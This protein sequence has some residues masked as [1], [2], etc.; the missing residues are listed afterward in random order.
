MSIRDLFNKDKS[1][2]ILK[3]NSQEELGLEVESSGNVAAKLKEDKRFLPQVDFSDPSNFAFYG[4][5][6]QYYSDSINRIL[7]SYPYDGSLKERAE[8]RND[9]IY[10]D[11]YVLDNLYPR[12]NGYVTL[13]S[14]YILVDGG[15]NAAPSEYNN[16]I[17]PEKFD[18]SN[19][20]SVADDRESNLE[21]DFEKGVTVEFWMKFGT[22]FL[23]GPTTVFHLTGTNGKITIN[24]EVGGTPGPWTITM[25]SGSTTVTQ[26]GWSDPATIT[27]WNHYAFS[28]ASGSTGMITK[29]Y[30][31]GQLLHTSATL[32]AMGKVIA[33]HNA[34]INALPNGSQACRASYDEFRFWKTKR[35]SED[36]GRYWFTQVGGGTNTDLANTD[37]G[38]YFKFNE[39][40]TGD[41]ST[42]SAILDYSGRFS[43]GTW[44]G[45]NAT[46]S[47]RS[48]GSAMVEASA[49]LKEFKD[50]IIYSIHPD[51]I[52]LKEA[53]I[54]SGSA[55]DF[56]NNSSIYH[57]M[58]NWIV[59]EDRRDAGDAV[60]KLTQVMGSY[61]DTLQLQMKELPKLKDMSYPQIDE[62]E[63]PNIFS[64]RLL[65]GYGFTAP[66]IFANADVISQILNRD[67]ER[68]FDLELNDIKNL[69]YKNIYNNLLHI[70]K[71]KGT[72]K[73]FRN[74]IRCY[75][76]DDSLIRLNLY[77]DNTLIE[78]N[79]D[80]YR[81]DSVRKKY[82]DFNNPDRFAG[83]VYQQTASGNVNSISYI[84]AS[85]NFK[86][87]SF[88][89]EGEILFPIKLEQSHEAYFSTP[90][91]TAS[92]LGF[93]GTNGGFTWLDPDLRV[94]AIRD[95]SE[96]SNIRFRLTSSYAGINLETETYDNT[97]DNEKWNL[98]VR[99]KP[100]G[101]GTDYVTNAFDRGYTLEFY[102]VNTEAGVLKNEF[103]LS[104]SLAS[105]SVGQSFLTQPKRIYAGA[106]YQNFT[107][108]IQEKTD[109][110]ISS[111]RYW[112]SY[113]END[114]IKAH[115]R[116]PESYG[117]LA[118]YNNI[119]LF[120][121]N[122]NSI[123][124]PQAETLFLDWEFNLVSS[125]NGAGEFTVLDFSSGSLANTG[126][127]G[128][129]SA[130]S[131]RQHTGVGDEFLANN[132]K[133]VDLR[134]I[135]AAK[136]LPVE[137]IQQSNMV[138][139]LSQDDIAFSRETRPQQYYYAFEKS[140]YQTISD[141]MLNFFATVV[142][143][144]NLI[145]S[146]VNRYR[147]NYKAM[148]KLREL[149][150][151]RVGNT[152]DLDRYVE[153]YKWIDQ[154][155]GI[156]I[157]ELIPAS[158]N[159]SEQIRNMVESH[160]L[161][162]NKYWSKFPTLEMKQEDP[163]AGLR[164]INELTYNWK[165]G[166]APISGTTAPA[167]QNENCFWWK[168]RAE[169]SGPIL[170][171]SD[172]GVNEDKEEILN[173]TLQALN[174]GYTT[175]Y[176]F[177]IDESPVVHGGVNFAR[178]KSID[179]VKST[180]KFGTTTGVTV[181]DV[182]P[183]KDCDDVYNPL[184]K[185]KLEFK[186][187][188]NDT[189]YRS[190]KGDLFVPFSLYSSSLY[191]DIAPNAR[192]TN[193]HTDTYGNDKGVPL[194]GPATYDLVGG[195]QYRHNEP[196]ASDRLEGWQITLDTNLSASN[197]KAMEFNLVDKD[198]LTITNPSWN[199]GSADQS[200]TYSISAWVY[201][202]S[203]A[204][205]FNTIF[206]ADS[207]NAYGVKLTYFSLSNQWI[208][209]EGWSNGQGEWTTT[210]PEGALPFDEWAHVVL[211]H[212][213]ST[214]DGGS[215]PNLYIN[216]NPVGAISD[217]SIPCSGTFEPSR[218]GLPSAIGNNNIGA[219][220]T[221][222]GSLDELAYWKKAL[223]SEEVAEIYNNG[224]VADLSA[225]TAA[226]DNTLVSWY[227]MGDVV[228]DTDAGGIIYDAMG[229]STNNATGSATTGPGP[230][231]TTNVVS[232]C[233]PLD[234][235]KFI[236]PNVHKPRGMYYREPLAKR[237]VN[238]RN[239]KVESLGN[240]T[241]DWEVVHTMGRH[242]NNVQ[243]VKDGGFNLNLDYISSSFP[244]SPLNDVEKIIR[245]RHEQ[246]FV[247]RFSAPGDPS[248]MGDSDGGWGL[249]RYSAELS[250]NNDMNTRNSDVRDI[251]RDQ[252]SSHVNQFGYFSAVNMRNTAG[253]TV[254][255]LNYS[256]VGSPYQVNRNTQYRIEPDIGSEVRFSLKCINF[257]TGSSAATYR[258]ANAVPTLQRDLTDPTDP[259]SVAVWV[260]PSVVEPTLRPI[261]SCGGLSGATYNIQWGI[262][263]QSGS[264]YA[265]AYASGTETTI[266]ASSNVIV[267]PLGPYTL[268]TWYL[269]VLNYTR[270]SI[271]PPTGTLGFTVGNTATGATARTN[272]NIS[273]PGS[274]ANI[275]TVGNLR[276]LSAAKTLMNAQIDDV[277]FYNTSL[278]E[279]QVD[280]IF[281]CSNPAGGVVYAPSNV[282][283]KFSE[284]DVEGYI[285]MGDTSGD[286][287]AS[288]TD[289]TSNG[290]NFTTVAGSTT[291]I[292]IVSAS[293][294]A[295][296]TEVA[297]A[298]VYDNYYVQHN[299][300]RNDYRYAWIT[301]S[302]ISDQCTVSSEDIQFVSASDYVSYQPSGGGASS[303]VFGKDKNASLP[304]G[305]HS[306]I[307]TDFAGLNIN[308]EEDIWP[309]SSLIGYDSEH[310]Y[311]G[312]GT[313]A[314][315]P[316]L[317]IPFI[318]AVA[319]SGGT[320]DFFNSLLLNRQG[321]YGW[322]S[323][324]QIRGYQNPLTRYYRSNNLITNNPPN[325]RY[326]DNT[327]GD[328]Y[329]EQ[330][331][332]GLETFSETPVLSKYKNLTLEL[333]M[334]VEEDS[335]VDGSPTSMLKE[336]SLEL[337]YGNNLGHF[338]ND[339]LNLQTTKGKISEQ[340]LDIL[341]RYYLNGAVNNPNNT[342][343]EFVSL[344]YPEIV[345]PAEENWGT[346]KIR[347]RTQ[348]ECKFWKDSRTE[349]NLV[350]S[351]ANSQ[352]IQ[353]GTFVI[354]SASLATTDPVEYITCFSQSMWP[355]DARFDF[356]TADTA[357]NWVTAIGTASSNFC[358]NTGSYYPHYIGG[359][360]EL[361]SPA[362]QLH[363]QM[364]I[365]SSTN[366][367]TINRPLFPGIQYHRR[368]TLPMS[369]SV[370]A[371]SGYAR[372]FNLE[373]FGGY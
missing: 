45:Y 283:S 224:C 188:T 196:L 107:G 109:V 267:D 331:Y 38:I 350:N 175:P 104:S 4:S 344:K 212:D 255:A 248:T 355:L 143:F 260:K 322:P 232:G 128:F 214:P 90:F 35:T 211:S 287:A 369:A 57:T 203:S 223:T 304:S 65:E 217:A 316:Y 58:P 150:F 259:F 276:L 112:G 317:A 103:L 173:V 323:W 220:R 250:P 67:E 163:E 262:W 115:A 10:L 44:V 116:D 41:T 265:G 168:Q 358:G 87:T 53:L 371:F 209:T 345:Y 247:N 42:D 28:I 370:M 118:P 362:P 226:S 294:P 315:A 141:D 337:P 84:S 275:V 75:G 206:A 354:S 61:F 106:R 119:T 325:P 142:D 264:F 49:S 341:K 153:F 83:T 366:P 289:I 157:Q 145:G 114:V 167:P 126:R 51:V 329:T 286:T 281:S 279:A 268:D 256:G 156:M 285:L 17:L 326:F 46:T 225:S 361:Q 60:L 218:S 372:G 356:A 133:V 221:W 311:S 110:K 308:M 129:Y 148:E 105:S 37:L 293:H 171:S 234:T 233:T 185:S 144:N 306:Y 2:K 86:Y 117:A 162:R 11:L 59:E 40:I 68:E 199:S 130:V 359:E 239:K 373:G 204:S 47:Y 138:N 5:A 340:S 368:Q 131:K 52:T 245:N 328:L 327:P 349:R 271:L 82:V 240:Y 64:N 123:Q 125:S 352:G 21:M 324:K 182:Q 14:T 319:G 69:I 160:V 230:T 91:I 252:L 63:K 244:N 210:A 22:P 254:N 269:L 80:K 177:D 101:Y 205:G 127:Y 222:P 76:I 147:Q 164:G 96:S 108:S 15:P 251:Y 198:I 33:P 298:A 25:D 3:A 229:V 215:T 241:K 339:L 242:E 238:I 313:S 161:E 179:Y 180:I 72:Q 36:I 55:Y 312:P 146:P 297:C 134:N 95:Y 296:S 137:T 338:S 195:L 181:E 98:A 9:S 249:D 192:I 295:C 194:Q 50:P 26:S 302:T 278:S 124:I 272:I 16:K 155:L 111:V 207:N 190:G 102:G 343:E 78:A 191:N 30:I 170:S 71:T 334:R 336:V 228:G 176:R 70:Y 300:P 235:I 197:T 321:P 20:Y 189:S 23:A 151:E 139:V 301:A 360:G 136:Q 335:D 237:P 290:H 227:R 288:L 100:Q 174:R 342:I 333:L 149:F 132:T 208:I 200:D 159:F 158:A 81:T 186:A 284:S 99:Y 13:D 187:T 74:L 351:S 320:T 120:D 307:F 193:L 183:L 309:D 73:S 93:H 31:N 172:A 18:K 365:S 363:G 231:F 92:L 257:A 201:L 97:Y 94:Y 213:A 165:F 19:F 152:P 154:S 314:G 89:M 79:A 266:S 113:L 121:S 66:E 32:P 85:S 305:A 303:R 8:F 135:Y 48:T 122:L 219:S 261:V 34:S 246:V 330:K 62:N 39:G 258:I 6:E 166:H 202:T 7:D 253:S 347:S 346:G 29:Q 236:Y 270:P 292:S 43:N 216:T 1:S 77:A 299:I 12:T 367:L 27:D 318:G 277:S 332:K 263:S 140:M 353:S 169:R 364:T 56:K 282:M 54:K 280:S 357:Y 348:F 274:Y 243:F 24:H 273:S 88:T 310:T 184:K 291:G 178:N